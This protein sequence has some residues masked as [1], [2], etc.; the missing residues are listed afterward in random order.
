[1]KSNSSSSFYSVLKVICS[2]TF[3]LGTMFEE[4]QWHITEL[5]GVGYICTVPIE[6][7]KQK[8]DVYRAG[9][10][11]LKSSGVDYSDD[12]K[13]QDE[14][15]CTYEMHLSFELS[16]LEYYFDCSDK[17]QSSPRSLKIPIRIHRSRRL[18][19]NYWNLVTIF[20]TILQLVLT[21]PGMCPHSN[22]H[23]SLLHNQL[24]IFLL[25]S[26]PM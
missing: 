13:N 25:A 18:V 26:S 23:T 8:S 16:I 9:K 12:P 2:L 17:V 5:N 22:S 20:L 24:I 7:D 6:F 4:R 21:S 10:E 11:Y 15:G 3:N 14:W 1:M 19:S